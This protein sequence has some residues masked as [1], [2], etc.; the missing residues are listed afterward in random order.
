MSNDIITITWQAFGE[1]TSATITWEGAPS[2][3]DEVCN[4][5]YVATNTYQG[6]LWDVLE[7]FLPVTR[8]HT[9]LSIGDTVTVGGCV[10]ECQPIGWYP[11][12]TQPTTTN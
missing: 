5:L 11:S 8:T 2:D 12:P 1:P 7:P 9:A 10:M 6:A 3:P 4:A